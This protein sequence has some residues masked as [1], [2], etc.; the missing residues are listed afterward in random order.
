MSYIDPKSIRFVD[1]FKI[2]NTLDPDFAMLHTHSTAIQKYYMPKYYIPKG[3]WWLDVRMKEEMDFLVKVESVDRPKW[4]RA[5]SSFRLY[6]RKKLLKKG[7]IPNFVHRKE[8]RLGYRLVMVD[9]SIIRLYVDPEF[10]QG[11]HDIVYPYVPKGEIWVEKNLHPK[12]IPFVLHH[13]ITE[14]KLMLRGKNYD[15]AHEYGTTAEK[16]MRRAHGGFYPMDEN[17]P[18]TK[19]IDDQIRKKYYV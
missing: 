6:L 12:E 11:G 19:L 18:W 13:E 7:S 4:I 10:T 17:Y 15:I 9:G 3:E 8:W 16:D 1:G 5:G 2:R 14:R